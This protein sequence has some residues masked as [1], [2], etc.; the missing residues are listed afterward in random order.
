MVKTM[1]RRRGRRRPMRRPLRGPM[2]RPM[3]RG[4]VQYQRRMFRRQR[5]MIRRTRRFMF[6]SMIILAIGNSRNNYKF[7]QDDL[8][9]I[10][11]YHRKPAEDLTEAELFQAMR[12]LGINH[13]DIDEY[14][15]D[16]MTDDIGEEY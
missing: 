7:H 6:G 3:R 4:F 13:L 14:E 1:A 12:K 5:R 10:E 15:N 16:K 9:R 11:D 2:R 8:A